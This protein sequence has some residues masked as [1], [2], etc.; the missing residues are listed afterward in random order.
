MMREGGKHHSSRSSTW[1]RQMSG[2]QPAL[3]SSVG[4]ELSVVRVRLHL[5]ETDEGI[6]QRCESIRDVADNGL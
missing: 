2:A 4:D 1:Y 5:G 6:I 3:Q